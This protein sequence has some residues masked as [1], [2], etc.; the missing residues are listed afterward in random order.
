M[1]ELVPT[2]QKATG[3]GI[4]EHDVSTETGKLRYSWPSPHWGQQALGGT[5]IQTEALVGPTGGIRAQAQPVRLRGGKAEAAC[6]L[7][8][9]T[10]RDAE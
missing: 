6:A 1:E 4:S 10:L 8:V 9:R 7:L 2:R 5:N 3:V